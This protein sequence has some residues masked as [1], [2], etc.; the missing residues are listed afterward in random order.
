MAVACWALPN[1]LIERSGFSPLLMKLGNFSRTLVAGPLIRW[2]RLARS[3]ASRFKAWEHRHPRQ[4]AALAVL[5]ALLVCSGVVQLLST[6]VESSSLAMV[7]MAGATAVAIRSGLRSAAAFVLLSVT[8]YDLLF[9][10][11]YWTLTKLE[12]H[13]YLTFGLMLA[14]GGLISSLASNLR[15]KTLEIVA[16]ARRA[17]ARNALANDLAQATTPEAIERAVGHAIRSVLRLRSRLGLRAE[18]LAAV[19]ELHLPL[20]GVAGQMG[21]LIVEGGAPL[22][23]RLARRLDRRSD[24]LELLRAFADQ[25]AIALERLHLEQVHSQARVEAE[26]ERLRSTLLAAISHDFRTPITTIVGSVSTLLEQRGEIAPEQREALLRSVLDQ[27]SRVHHLMS[28]LLDLTRIEGGGVQARFEWCPV[29][30]LVA[31]VLQPLEG[32][33]RDFRV[34][35]RFDPEG[36]LWCDPR[37]LEQLLGNLLVNAGAHAPRGSAIDVEIEVVDGEA[38]VTVLDDGPGFPA[39]RE[40]DMVKKFARGTA[41]SGQ[42]TGLG[43]AICAAIAR[44]HGG[45]LAVANRGGAWVQFTLPQPAVAASPAEAL[46]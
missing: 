29:D 23:R 9:L 42:G 3:R 45:S 8:T 1:P 33:L 25:A 14:V 27:A 36:L 6:V 38:R 24:D 5:L 26:A 46:A 28:N 16:K 44:L 11:P 30:E 7:Y 32:T 31:A 17:R 20:S 15:E 18:A 37:L 19:D 12:P 39:G 4:S 43:L 2:R 22:N 34:T 13:H 10:K 40:Q 41:A 21:V 35:T